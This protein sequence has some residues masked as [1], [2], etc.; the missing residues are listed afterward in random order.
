MQ[1]LSFGN[2]SRINNK[3]FLRNLNKKTIRIAWKVFII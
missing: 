2:K 1:N 3:L